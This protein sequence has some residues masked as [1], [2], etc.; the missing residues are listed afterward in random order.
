LTPCTQ[1]MLAETLLQAHSGEESFISKDFKDIFLHQ[2]NTARQAQ[3]GRGGSTEISFILKFKPDP[4]LFCQP[5]TI[6]IC[7]YYYLL[8]HNSC[9]NITYIYNYAKFVLGCL[10]ENRGP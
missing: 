3:S 4:H 5:I 7:N 1:L 6:S 2:R 10:G 9:A 8:K